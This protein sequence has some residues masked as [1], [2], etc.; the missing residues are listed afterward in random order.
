MDPTDIRRV[1]V[2]AAALALAACAKPGA[3]PNEGPD[4]ILAQ[5]GKDAPVVAGTAEPV[6]ENNVAGNRVVFANAGFEAPQQGGGTLEA[7]QTSQH[8]G[9]HSYDFDLDTAIKHGRTQSLRVT[10]VGPEPYGAVYQVL[11]ADT[12]RGRTVEF[13]GWL[14]TAGATGRGAQLTLIARGSGAILAHKFLNDPGVTG[15]QEWRRY[16]IRLVVPQS[17]QRVEFG[18]MLVGPGTMWLDDTALHI[19]K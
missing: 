2:L 17:A 1:L 6:G 12:V 11:P 16:S 13:S 19:I 5:Q 14:R 10:S 8:A 4:A 15:T 9:V 3:A 7:W 18:A